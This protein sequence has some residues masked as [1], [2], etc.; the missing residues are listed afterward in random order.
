MPNQEHG[1]TEAL[2]KKGPRAEW[3]FFRKQRSETTTIQPKLEQETERTVNIRS[4]EPTETD[5]LLCDF[6][7]SFLASLGLFSPQKEG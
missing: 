1:L 5:R 2:R 3:K 4:L 6:W 7:A